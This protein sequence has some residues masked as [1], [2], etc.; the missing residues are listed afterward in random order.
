MVCRLHRRS[1]GSRPLRFVLDSGAGAAA[2]T[3]PAIVDS[4]NLNIAGKM[5]VRG[6]GGGGSSIRGFSRGKCDL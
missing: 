6:A 1:M 5:Q 3:N 4:L 2:I